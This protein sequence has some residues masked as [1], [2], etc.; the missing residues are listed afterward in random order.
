M[1]RAA[2]RSLRSGASTRTAWATAIGL[3]ARRD[4]SEEEVR[5]KLLDREFAEREVEETVSRLRERRYLDD[6]ALA[7]A[8]A[9]ARSR[10]KHHGPLKVRAYLSKRQ[11]PEEL[12][13]EAIRV[14]FPEGA[15][16]ERAEIALRR[17]AR[18][19]NPNPSAGGRDEPGSDARRK[20]NARLFR[21]LVA[22]GYSWEAARRALSELGLPPEESRGESDP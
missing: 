13:R 10:T 15:E 2:S 5:L 3:L 4:L 18:S 11:I 20:A 1:P 21:R 6:R 8:V 9:R 17:M 19:T 12:A 22:R 14:E 16:L 7:L